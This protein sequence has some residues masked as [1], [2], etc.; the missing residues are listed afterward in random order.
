MAESLEI[1]VG[2]LIAE[3]F[4]HALGVLRALAAAGAVS[5]RFF[6]A[7]FDDLHDFLVFV[8]PD[9]HIFTA[10]LCL[11]IVYLIFARENKHISLF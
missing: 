5:A 9:F 4:A 2:D 3:L 1:R 6:Q 10:L 11:F 7:L 8:V